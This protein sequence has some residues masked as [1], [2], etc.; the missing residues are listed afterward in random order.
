MRRRFE[1]LR[2]PVDRY[3]ATGLLLGHLDLAEGSLVMLTDGERFPIELAPALRRWA[4]KNPLEAARPARWIAYPRTLPDGLAFYVVGQRRP[5]AGETEAQINR[6][7]DRFQITGALVNSRGRRRQTCIRICRN[8]PAPK[9][10]KRH[11]SWRPRLLFLTGLP[12]APTKAWWGSDV[13]IQAVREGRELRIL[14]MEKV[15]AAAVHRELPL[16]A[17]NLP[18]PWRPSSQAIWRL[19]TKG[20]LAAIPP[21]P[22]STAK[23]DLILKRYLAVATVLLTELAPTTL[24]RQAE[25]VDPS[26][27]AELEALGR[28][29]L[30]LLRQWLASTDRFLQGLPPSEQEGLAGFQL[31]QRLAMAAVVD[32]EGVFRQ[33]GDRFWFEGWPVRG[34]AARVLRENLPLA[35]GETLGAAPAQE[36]SAIP[37]KQR[38]Q[39]EL[40]VSNPATPT[41]KRKAPT[42]EEAIEA[43]VQQAQAE[44]WPRQLLH[45]RITRAIQKLVG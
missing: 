20:E 38:R 2:P 5:L 21:W 10:K 31:K 15:G 42:A 12:P 6:Q 41:R 36:A 1:Q 25:Q 29:H 17:A 22:A 45:L 4:E 37:T 35:G 11:P 9:G 26:K 7:I 14:A 28:Q 43:L 44:G 3:Q 33:E 19:C 8:T 16:G 27:R 32:L 40:T 18:W 39:V 13:R 23:A 34:R 30:D 24:A